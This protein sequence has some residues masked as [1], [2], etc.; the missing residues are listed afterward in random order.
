MD[1]K[2]ALQAYVLDG[3]IM[4]IA[5][6][7]AAF[8]AVAFAIQGL[9]NLRRARICPHGFEARLATLVPAG[10]TRAQW[11]AR[12]NAEGHSMAL[13]LARVLEHLDRKPDADP[14]EILR[15]EIE[16]ECYSL[17]QRNNQ[18]NLIYNVS[19]LMGLLGTVI[20]MLDSFGKFA[21]SENPS[22]RDLNLG[23]SVAL[24]TTAWGLAIAIPSYMMLYIFS[25][26]IAHYEAI[27]LPTVGKRCLAALLERL[28]AGGA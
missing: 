5:L 2:T 6:V 20:G 22:G 13:V 3:G 10:A 8:L 21:L 7:P 25:R 9:I 24:I 19:P 28:R 23:I 12:L 18:L 26:R 15:E 27:A 16:E 14:L 17:V 1:A 4:M 11:V